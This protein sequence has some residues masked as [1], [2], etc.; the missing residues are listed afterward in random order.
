MGG[1]ILMSGP[2]SSAWRPMWHSTGV[3]AYPHTKRRFYEEA[4]NSGS[5]FQY[6]RFH[7]NASKYSVGVTVYSVAGTLLGLSS[8]VWYRHDL[9]IAPE[10]EL[11]LAD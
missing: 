9:S 3:G 1:L 2:V 7:I 4:Y 8:W 5:V 10:L 6:D 11:L